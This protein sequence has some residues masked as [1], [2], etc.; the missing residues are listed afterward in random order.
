MDKKDIR[1]KLFE[2]DNFE[3]QLRDL[4]KYYSG[5]LERALKYQLDRQEILKSRVNAAK[6]IIRHINGQKEDHDK[7]AQVPED[8]EGNP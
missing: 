7:S 5:S 6:K 8:I 2:K 3:V 4:S 1:Y